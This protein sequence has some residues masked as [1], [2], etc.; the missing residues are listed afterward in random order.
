M[1]R[2]MES[3]KQHVKHPIVS[4]NPKPATST[5]Q[6]LMPPQVK[7]VIPIVPQF[8]AGHEK[9]MQWQYWNDHMWVWMNNDL[10]QELTEAM[11]SGL[12]MCE[13]NP[14]EYDLEK[15]IQRNTDTGKCRG[16]VHAQWGHITIITLNPK[17][18]DQLSSPIFHHLSFDLCESKHVQQS[19][20][21]IC[22]RNVKRC[23][24]EWKAIEALFFNEPASDGWLVDGADTEL[25]IPRIV[26]ITAHENPLQAM[27]YELARQQIIL[28]HAHCNEVLAFHGTYYRNPQ[29]IVNS[30]GLDTRYARDSNLLFG[31]AIYLAKHA[32]FVHEA[33]YAYTTSER[34]KGKRK[35]P[36]NNHDTSIYSMLCV[37]AAVGHYRYYSPKQTVPKMNKAP[38]GYD[39]VYAFTNDA[40]FPMYVIH[41]N[42]QIYTAY[43]IQYSMNKKKQAT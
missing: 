41:D 3:W 2:W 37:K 30:G 27:R 17:H 9:Q 40:R 43:T 13:F 7:E 31:R 18:R 42:N 21:T 34:A 6:Q 33:R 23:S 14:Y 22:N 36:Q 16:I 39:S 24:N 26:Q 15:M 5:I 32:Q 38:A 29:H 4:Y 1:N 20:T 12:R 8:I 11:E 35:R 25:D 28:R 19:C 10:D